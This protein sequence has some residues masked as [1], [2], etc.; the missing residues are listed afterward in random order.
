[1]QL[2][3]LIRQILFLILLAEWVW[4]NP[5]AADTSSI[6]LTPLFLEVLAPPN[7]VKGSDGKFHLVYELLVTNATSLNWKIDSLEILDPQ[8]PHRIVSKFG[9]KDLEDRMGILGSRK[10]T[11]SLEPGQS[12]VV[13]IHLYFT[14][15]KDIPVKLSHRFNL[16]SEKMTFQQQGG[17]TEVGTAPRPV[18]GPPLRGKNWMAGDGCCESPRHIRATMPVDGKLKTS[19]RFAIDWV[20]L[21]ENARSLQGDKSKVESY[22]CYGQDIIAVADGKVV[23]VMD[24]LSNQIPGKL[25]EN[26]DPAQ[27]DGNHVI[28]ELG[29]KSYALYA[30]MISG[31]IRVKKGVRVKKGEVIGR[32]GNSGNTSEPHLHFHL[33]DTPS[34][35][36]S[37][38]LPYLLEDFKLT[39]RVPSMDDYDRAVNEGTSVEILPVPTPG[40][41]HRELPLDLSV[42]SFP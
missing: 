41:H 19:Q 3:I 16:L 11:V 32:V 30:H 33:M 29:P 15:S 36:G 4:V 27:A 25:P 37:N 5:L 22:H 23:T 17:F 40:A 7:S 14:S 21:G 8:S 26:I 35:F 13:W 6:G 31:S 1:M 20:L 28:Q 24:G 18:L 34:T 38:G 12:A 2:T 9:G 42:V 39:G 10:P